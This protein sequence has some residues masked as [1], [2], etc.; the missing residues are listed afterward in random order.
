[1]RIAMMVAGRMCYSETPAALTGVGVVSLTDRSVDCLG[2][3]IY[4]SVVTSMLENRTRAPEQNRRTRVISNGSTER[5]L[6]A[7][8]A[9]DARNSPDSSK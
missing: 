1:M 9:M 6:V 7:V 4:L 5:V 2:G 8:P 3:V